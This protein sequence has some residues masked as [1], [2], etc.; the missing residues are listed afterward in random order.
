M[1]R[2]FAS[3]A[4]EQVLASLVE[5]WAS[6]DPDVIM[7]PSQLASE[8][9]LAWNLM[10]PGKI[11]CNLDMCKLPRSVRVVP[12]PAPFMCIPWLMKQHGLWFRS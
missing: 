2:D 12:D 3:R 5:G 4:E 9:T 1:L 10:K 8:Q 11:P 7:N 6:V